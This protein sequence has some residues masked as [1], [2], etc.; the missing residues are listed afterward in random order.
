MMTRVLGRVAVIERVASI[1]S[2][3]GIRISIKTASGR[4]RRASATA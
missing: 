1:P 4:S 3:R 2:S